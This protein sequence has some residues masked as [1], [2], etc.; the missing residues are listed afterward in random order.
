MLN[1]L[2]KSFDKSASIDPVC[3]MHASN[4]ITAVYEGRTYVFCTEHCKKEFEK[5]PK[6]TSNDY[7]HC[8]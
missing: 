4:D 6:R 1:F 3:G 5:D 8:D 7:E 2:R